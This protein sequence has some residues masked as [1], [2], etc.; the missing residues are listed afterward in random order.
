MDCS[1]IPGHHH[2]CI[3]LED[4]GVSCSGKLMILIVDRVVH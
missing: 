1:S 2:D 3:H 4:A